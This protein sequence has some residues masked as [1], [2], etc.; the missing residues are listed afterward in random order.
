MTTIIAKLSKGHWVATAHDVEV[1]AHERYANSVVVANSDR[2]YLCVL[3]VAAQAQLGR[4]RG[5]PAAANIDAQLAVLA[6][7]HEKFYPAVLRGITTPD[8]AIE[9]NLDPKEQRARSLERNSRSAFARSANSTLVAF[10]KGGG[11]LRGLD[12]ETVTKTALRAAVA[13]PE[14]ENR[15]ARQVQRARGVL[16]R[17]ITRRARDNPDEAATEVESLMD[18]L[19]KVLDALN[20]EPEDEHVETATIASRPPPERSFQRT[21]VGVPQLHRGV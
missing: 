2:T 13:P 17:A 5:R 12:A 6:S 9:P 3:V 11:D 20:G 16:L 1:L 10:V 15:A 19:Q 8:I 14:P 21:R 4:P 7:V 18:D